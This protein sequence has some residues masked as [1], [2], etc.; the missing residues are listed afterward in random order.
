MVRF[1]LPV[2]LPSRRPSQPEDPA[3]RF[4][5]CCPLAHLLVVIANSMQLSLMVIFLS[6]LLAKLNQD[7]VYSWFV[8]F[9]PL[10]LSDTITIVNSCYELRRVVR[11]PT[12][13][14]M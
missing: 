2:A 11:M 9:I 3:Q 12:S 5:L 14:G 6:L 10:W 4:Q 13:A 7:G 8:I 1:R